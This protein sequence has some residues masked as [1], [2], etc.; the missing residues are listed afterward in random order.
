MRILQFD[1]VHHTFKCQLIKIE[2]VTHVIVGR[3]GLRVVVDHDAAVALLADG[4]E[5]L[6]ATPVELHRRADA[7]STRPEHDDRLAVGAEGDVALHARIGDIEVVGL[8]RILRGQGVN[9]LDNGQDAIRLALAAHHEHGL[10]HVA[11]LGLEADGTGNLEVGE[12]INLGLA[13][14]VAVQ[15]VDVLSLQLLIDVDDVL[16]LIEEPLVYLGQVMYLV[17]GVSLVHGLGDDKD[18]LV[19]GLTE[20]LVDIGNFQFLVLHKSVHALSDHAQS[21]LQGLLKVSSDGHHLADTLHRRAQLLVDATELAQVPSGNF[22]DHIVECRLKEGAGGLGHRVFQFKKPIAHAQLSGH[23]SQG[24]ACGLGCKRR[25]TAQSGVDLDDTI[26]LAV[27]V[28]SILHVA[29]SDDADVPDDADGQVAQLVILRIG[30]RLRRGDDD[31]LSGMD[32]QRVEVLHVT[33]G[34]AVVE[35]VAHHLILYFLPALQALFHQHLG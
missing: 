4:V 12:A 3:H 10:V 24:I 29:L 28:E 7:V 14:Q 33:H 32:A 26:V 35:T 1:D 11:Q 16:Q 22:A 19:R 2:T 30:K 13:H 34:D 31:A 17:D 9:L 23:E 27:G 18:T 25:A 21:L 5:R 15:R 8:R 20:R 6:H